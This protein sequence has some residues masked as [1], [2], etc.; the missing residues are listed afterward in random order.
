[1]NMV[2]ESSD[3]SLVLSGGS[4]NTLASDSLGGDPSFKAISN[5]MNNLFDDNTSNQIDSGYTDYR[6]IYIFNDGD[7]AFY[8][9][10]VYISNETTDGADINIG[11]S[12]SLT[13]TQ[14]IKIVNGLLVT[15][16]SIN[17]SYSGNSVVIPHNSDL[18][19][20][21]SNFENQFNS[22]DPLSGVNCSFNISGNDVFF[23]ISFLDLDD[24]KYHDTISLVSNSL[25]G[26]DPSV[27]ITKLIDGGP[28]N[29]VATEIGFATNEPASVSFDSY[30]ISNKLFIGT[31][32]PNE[33][34]PLWFKRT[35]NSTVSFLEDSVSIRV[36]GTPIL[37]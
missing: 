15:S 36:E 22:I 33:G 37:F 30:T 13:D 32:Y 35:V 8:N 23:E 16:G 29:T 34:F 7:S 31:L 9:V 12:T 25:V 6:C 14:R 2:V 24:N 5:E 21:S 11:V 28:I 17:L 26:V 3:I 4:S 20:W 19:V 27:V 18:S 1:M 10:Y